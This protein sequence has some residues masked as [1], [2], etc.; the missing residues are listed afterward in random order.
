MLQWWESGPGLYL[1]ATI[2]LGGHAKAF[3]QTTSDSF[4][5][6][7][8]D[9]DPEALKL[10]GWRL[11]QFGDR[12]RLMQAN[13][14]QLPHVLEKSNREKLRGILFDI[15]ISSA[16]LEDPERGFSFQKNG[17][18]DMRMD[19]RQPLLANEIVHSWP[20]SEL[21]RIFRDFGE[22]RHAGR[23]ARSLVRRRQQKGFETTVELA[24]WI[25]SQIPRRGKIHPATRIFQALR[26]A[27]N[28]ELAHLQQGL[29]GLMP[30]LDS[31]GRFLVVSFH[32]LEDRLVK[33]TFRAWAA[34]GKGI[35]PL[36]KPMSPTHEEIRANPRSRSAKLRVF[37]KI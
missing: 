14:S 36:R 26:I 29:E 11:Q 32:S 4:R 31:K 10:S 1:D 35:L 19:R 22:E 33:N 13:F 23:I 2:G 37:E 25:A 27:V 24:D 34:H 16:Q 3:L 7:G 8:A 5:L 9:R 18:L 30:L 20:E 15:G 12:V 28:D 21:F 6:L 17:P